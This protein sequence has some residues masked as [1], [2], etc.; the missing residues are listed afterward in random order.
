MENTIP[1]QDPAFDEVQDVITT[2]ASAMRTPWS[3]NA[4]WLDASVLPAR[5]AWSKAYGDY[6]NPATRTPVITQAKNGARS[7]YEPLLRQLVQVLS[8]N[9]AVTDDNLK[10]MD[11]HI[12]S[13]HRTPAPVPSTVPE[14][15][16]D[17][18]VHR[19]ISIHFRD[20]GSKSTAKPHGVN[21]A[22]IA[23]AVLD[24]PPVDGSELVHAAFDTKTPYTLDF[25]EAQRGKTVYVRLRWENTRAE[26]GPWSDIEGTII[27]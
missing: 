25:T 23:W 7:A 16:L 1:R 14:F 4:D 3:L 6:K 24:A 10:E 11:I 19:R 27:P 22:A 20:Q 8:N 18:A 17:S 5:A 15:T 21:G 13:K 2:K 12:R 26:V 9:P